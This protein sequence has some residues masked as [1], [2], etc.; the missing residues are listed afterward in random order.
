M[1][2]IFGVLNYGKKPVAGLRDLVTMLGIESAVRGTDATGIAFNYKNKLHIDKAPKSSLDFKFSVPKDV[3]AV[4]GHTRRTTIGKPEHNYNNHPF[5]GKAG[6]KH[7]AFAHNGVLDNE[8]ELKDMYKLPKT[9]IVTDSYVACQAME[10]LGSFTMKNLV[11]LGETVEGMFAFTFLDSQDNLYLI[12]NDSPLAVVHIPELEL[13]VYASTNDILI[14]ALVGWG[15]A[16]DS[17]VECL[18]GKSDVLEWSNPKEGSIIIIKSNGKVQ[19]G[20]F[21]PLQRVTSWYS[22]KWR[23]VA[24]GTSSF[25]YANTNKSGK[26]TG[27]ES[28]LPTTT[29][30]YSFWDE[31]DEVDDTYC[32]GSYVASGDLEY[33]NMLVEAY[34]SAGYDAEDVKLLLDDGFDLMTLEDFI[35]SAEQS[36]DFSFIDDVLDSYYQI[37]AGE[38]LLDEPYEVEDDDCIKVPANK[39]HQ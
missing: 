25:T 21:K 16:R 39:F 31:E 22:Q 26:K 10:K 36:G 18:K 5:K 8:F 7:F 30:R 2:G 28:L 14:K 35:F 37:G 19:T 29:N 12:R 15:G 4:M 13:Y 38:E 17:V 27:R 34:I 24:G 9:H 11:K 32:I 23:A 6:R 20:E 3:K 33:A 1:C